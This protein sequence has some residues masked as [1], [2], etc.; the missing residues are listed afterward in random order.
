MAFDTAIQKVIKKI[1]GV[2]GIGTSVTYRKV[3]TGTYNSTSGALG[4]TTSDT[5]LK[6]IFEDI[7]TREVTDL[8]EADDRKCIIPAASLSFTPTTADRIIAF[9][10]SYQITRIKI[11]QQAGTNL[12]YELYLRA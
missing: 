10:I 9:N 11:Q 3:T 7:N 2:P 12:N 4:E 6:V 5:T 8:V 1:V